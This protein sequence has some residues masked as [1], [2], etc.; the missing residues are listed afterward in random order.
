MHLESTGPIW[1]W[2][3]VIAGHVLYVRMLKQPGFAIL[4]FYLGWIYAQVVMIIVVRHLKDSLNFETHSLVA[5]W[6]ITV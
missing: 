1:W 4:S 6:S 5:T 2:E 3:E